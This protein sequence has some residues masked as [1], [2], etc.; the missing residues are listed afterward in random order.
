MKW[1]KSININFKRR[2]SN[3]ECQGHN[4]VAHIKGPANV[5]RLFIITH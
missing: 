4:N 3:N 2:D 1:K 5:M